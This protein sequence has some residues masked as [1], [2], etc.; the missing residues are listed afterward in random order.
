MAVVFLVLF[1]V[2]F[3]FHTRLGLFFLALSIGML[4]RGAPARKLKVVRG[5]DPVSQ[6][7]AWKDPWGTKSR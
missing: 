5:E 3:L 2:T 4:Y 7:P 1:L 6:Q